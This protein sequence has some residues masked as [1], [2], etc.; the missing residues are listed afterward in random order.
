MTVYYKDTALFPVGNQTNTMSGDGLIYLTVSGST[1]GATFS[2]YS[3]EVNKTTLI[4]SIPDIIG[5]G[6]RWVYGVTLNYDGS[7]MSYIIGVYN[8]SAYICQNRTCD[9]VGNTWIHRTATLPITYFSTVPSIT[10]S[11]DGSTLAIGEYG[12]SGEW[13]EQG[14]VHIYKISGDDWVIQQIITAPAT[15]NAYKLYFGQGISFNGDGTKLLIGAPGYRGT[16]MVLSYEYTTNWELQSTY[17][18]P[19]ALSSASEPCVGG[20]VFVNSTFTRAVII[21]N[22]ADY[23]SGYTITN[24]NGVW[25]NTDDITGMDMGSSFLVLLFYENENLLVHVYNS[26]PVIAMKNLP[27]IRGN[28]LQGGVPIDCKIEL[29]NATGGYLASTTSSAVDGSFTITSP[30]L[31]DVSL[32]IKSKSTLY[33]DKIYKMNPGFL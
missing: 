23:R 29:Y 8:G 10:I 5:S 28:T 7:V 26:Q 22:T 9:R 15:I 11:K 6:T 20:I 25:G 27:I 18:Y 3:V 1:S 16:G 19:T 30:V 4:T 17:N 2:F 13:G 32:V 12:Y 14:R 31:S 24:T 33:N 21:R